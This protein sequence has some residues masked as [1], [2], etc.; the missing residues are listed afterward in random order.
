LVA[1]GTGS[2]LWAHRHIE[3][4][5]D[6]QVDAELVGVAARSIGP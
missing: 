2:Y 5:D 1:L 6:A 4:T 3:S